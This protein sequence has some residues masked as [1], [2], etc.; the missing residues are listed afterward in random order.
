M[1]SRQQMVA[2]NIASKSLLEH[3]GRTAAT[4]CFGNPR[5]MLPGSHGRIFRGLREVEEEAMRK[6]KAGDGKSWRREKEQ[7]FLLKT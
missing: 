7:K 1:A 4:F 2:R 5:V 3:L 6:L